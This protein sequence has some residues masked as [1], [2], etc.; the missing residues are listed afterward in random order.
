MSGLV[1]SIIQ[2]SVCRSSDNSVYGVIQ[3]ITL[4]FRNYLNLFNPNKFDKLMFIESSI[5]FDYLPKI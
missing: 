5:C 4:T 1:K 3:K 2:R